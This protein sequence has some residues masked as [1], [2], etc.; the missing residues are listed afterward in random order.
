LALFEHATLWDDVLDE[1]LDEHQAPELDYLLSK[2]PRL[3]VYTD[4][5]EFF[6]RTLVTEQMLDIIEGIVEALEGGGRHVYVL[7][8]FFGG[9]K[10]HTLFTLYHAVRDPEALL[11]AIMESAQSL[12]PKARVRF[13]ERGR[14]LVERLRGIRAPRVVLISGKIEAL[15]PTPSRPKRVG[16]VT[17]KTLW[18]YVAAMLGRYE[19]VEL[20]DRDVRAPGIDRLEKVLRGVPAL[21]LVDEAV[22]GLKRLAASD[23]AADRSYAEQV[24]SFFD[25]LFSAATRLGSRAAVVFTVPG[26][27][28]S[29]GFEWE[30]RYREEGTLFAKILE[31]ITRAVTRVSAS[32]IEPVSSGEFWRILQRRLF[33]RIDWDYAAR[34]SREL[35]ET[36]SQYRDVFGAAEDV[37]ESVARMYPLHPGFV[38]T[39]RDIVERNDSLQK[40]RDAL[41][42]ARRIV[43][44]LYRLHVEGGLAE[45]MLMA[46][47]IDPTVKELTDILRG[48]DSYRIV[49]DVDLEGNVRKV[50]RSELA[51]LLAVALF[52]RTYVY[53]SPKPLPVFPDARKAAVLVFEPSLFQAR[54]WLPTDIPEVLGELR[55]ALYYLWS[56]Q[57]RYWFWSVANVNQIIEQKAEALFRARYAQLLEEL[58]RSDGYL[59]GLAARKLTR[60]R[61]AGLGERYQRLLFEDLLVDVYAGPGSVPDE[62]RY[63]LVVAWR[64]ETGTSFEKIVT[65]TVKGGRVAPR[66]FRNAVV[67]LAPSDA[68]LADEAVKLYARV[69][70]AE[71]VEEELDALLGNL[72]PDVRDAVRKAQA[73]MVRN[74]RQAAEARLLE[75]LLSGFDRVYYPAPG[76]VRQVDASRLGVTALC[77]AEKAETTLASEGKA[78][79]RGPLS[80]DYLEQK[81]EEAGRSLREPMTVR[82]VVSAFKTDPAMPMVPR[83]LLLEALLEG[84]RRGVLLVKREGRVYYPRILEANECPSGGF[85]GN[86]AVSSL[87][88]EDE[89][90]RADTRSGAEML[91]RYLESLVG[92]KELPDG[93]VEIT[94]VKVGIEGDVLGLEEFRQLVAEDPSLVTAAVFCVARERKKPGVRLHVSPETVTVPAGEEVEVTVTP[95]R[96]GS[97]DPGVVRVEAAAPPGVEA[98]LDR[99]V[100]RPGEAARL[101]LRALDAGTYSVRL[102]AVPERGEP[103][104]AVV[105]LTAR[106][107]HDIVD[108]G[109]LDALSDAVVK[110]VTLE[111]PWRDIELALEDLTRLAAARAVA[112][113]WG[114]GVELKVREPRPA[115]VTLEAARNVARIIEEIIGDTP[116]AKVTVVFDGEVRPEDVASAATLSLTGEAT[117]RARVERR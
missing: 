44:R 36:Y 110:E 24:A 75:R 109:E 98:A 61:G 25:D 58:T 90:V 83:R 87:R 39:L 116:R 4:P 64:P 16:G 22:E 12:E 106:G 60:H 99:D 94:T 102:R 23:N 43:R 91:L 101:I 69:R 26:Q 105:T 63:V 111:G 93:T 37:A 62:D 84:H 51:R 117:C 78:V 85:E 100:L 46:W 114:G 32:F 27:R 88:D 55:E 112:E 59:R 52:S 96:V 11:R 86:V 18:G 35:E 13:V 42:I 54:Q 9:G 30:S 21:I 33:S 7:Y 41:K 40:T 3:R 73:V 82:E 6:S 53:N 38:E 80:F 14:R 56:D 45:D 76:G 65:H 1:A 57:E 68:G 108:C 10:T 81:L 115:D 47:H 66:V 95:Q 107:R 2:D 5:G 71:E 103:G 29:T 92:Q 72:D 104:E 74:A 34:L 31:D 49:V 97:V 28:V 77:L 50:E 79:L 17:V 8:S 89:V 70:A 20:E 48:Y 19:L 113:L 67:V 15:F